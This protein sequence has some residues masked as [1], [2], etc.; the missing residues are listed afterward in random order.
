MF[1]HHTIVISAQG[2]TL[3]DFMKYLLI[4]FVFYSILGFNSCD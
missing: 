4:K 2:L 1:C 3:H